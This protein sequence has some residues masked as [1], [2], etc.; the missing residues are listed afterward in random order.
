MMV[1]FI[2]EYPVVA[3]LIAL[4]VGLLFGTLLARIDI[5]RKR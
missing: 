1:E 2:Q 3:V 5:G 4:S